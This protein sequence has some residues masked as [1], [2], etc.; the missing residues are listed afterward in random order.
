METK[1]KSQQYEVLEAFKKWLFPSQPLPHIFLNLVTTENWRSPDFQNQSQYSSNLQI[2]A[3]LQINCHEV[4]PPTRI[5]C[6]QDL[7]ANFSDWYENYTKY[8]IDYEQYDLRDHVNNTGDHNNRTSNNFRRFDVNEEEE[9]SSSRREYSIEEASARVERSINYLFNQSNE[10]KEIRDQLVQALPPKDQP[11]PDVYI[12]YDNPLL[13]ELPLHL[14][15]EFQDRN[16]EP[17][18]CNLKTSLQNISFVKKKKPRILLIL[19][20]FVDIDNENEMLNWQAKYPDA[21][22]EVLELLNQKGVSDALWKGKWDVLYFGG[23]STTQDGKGIIYLKNDRSITLGDFKKGLAEAAKNGLQLAI[24][25]SCISLGAAADLQSAGVPMV[26]ATRHKMHNFIAPEFLEYFLDAYINADK[27]IKNAV[28]YAKERL[29]TDNPYFPCASW[30]PVVF[31]IPTTPAIHRPSPLVVPLIICIVAL[32]VWTTHSLGMFQGAELSLYDHMMNSKLS[33]PLNSSVVVI[34]T[35]PEDV[36]W[37]ENQGEKLVGDVTISDKFLLQLIQ[38][39][40]KE[41]PKV[42][43]MAFNRKGISSSSKEIKLSLDQRMLNGSEPTLI[44]NCRSLT[45]GESDYY[46]E[47]MAS[48]KLEP[49]ENFPLGDPRVGFTNLDFDD[50]NPSNLRRVVLMRYQKNSQCGTKGMVSFPLRL[51]LNFLNIKDEELITNSTNYAV[52]GRIHLKIQDIQISN[53]VK[54]E[55]GYQID[56]A[57]SNN[58]LKRLTILSNEKYYSNKPQVLEYTLKESLSGIDLFVKDKIV[59]IGGVGKDITTVDN[60]YRH[61]LSTDYFLSILK[62]KN[63]LKGADSNLSLINFLLNLCISTSLL[64]YLSTTL[65]SNKFILFLFF[66]IGNQLIIYFLY[67]YILEQIL[68]WIP[69]I[70]ILVG[71]LLCSICVSIATQVSISVKIFQFQDS[72]TSSKIY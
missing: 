44:N 60:V 40:D 66:T 43:G 39:L 56:P 18:F 71:T 3:S 28:W 52:D 55:G 31:Q 54:G 6:T 49:K 32:I 48:K 67:F 5:G 23:H 16:I 37:Q 42:I 70:P 38:K 11:Q 25:N 9:Y 33:T 1:Q 12:R 50:R 21:E 14:W 69:I 62:N 51:A 64:Y 8:A 10:F 68:L 4:V 57:H 46:P 36:E 26:V 13:A 58:A 47:V 2:I 61:A 35:T 63:Y 45:N 53:I 59:I 30:L 65:V 17:V 7:I 22:I 15:D 27:S 34:K 41:K 20:D 72:I 29:K 19:G 24:F